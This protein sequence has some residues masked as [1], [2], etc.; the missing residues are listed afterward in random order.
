MRYRVALFT[1]A[2][3]ASECKLHKIRTVNASKF[4]I[5]SA[6]VGN[7]YCHMEWCEHDVS[8]LKTH[9]ETRGVVYII[10]RGNGLIQ[11][12]W[13]REWGSIHITI[14]ELLPIV[15]SFA[16]WGR[17]WKGKTVNVCVTMQLWLPQ[18][19]PKE[20]RTIKLCI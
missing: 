11:F 18:L 4:P 7:I 20:A 8:P 1:P 17:Y 13:P 14:K 16:A 3:C 9:R 10:H 6:V 19:T 2:S 15:L 5:V 12:Q